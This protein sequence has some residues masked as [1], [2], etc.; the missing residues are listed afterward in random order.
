MP[1]QK[2]RKR[3]RRGW[4]RI[5]QAAVFECWAQSELLNRNWREESQAAHFGE[6]GVGL[7]NEWETSTKSLPQEDKMKKLGQLIKYFRYGMI[8]KIMNG[9]IKVRWYEKRIHVYEL[10]RF[11]DWTG[12][13]MVPDSLL[14]PGHS[15]ECDAESRLNWGL[16]RNGKR[17][18]NP[19]SY[20][21]FYCPRS[22]TTINNRDN[23]FIC[24]VEKNLKD[25]SK[26]V[27]IEGNHRARWH[28]R[29]SYSSFRR[30]TVKV[31][32]VSDLKDAVPHI[33]T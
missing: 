24:I 18:T 5:S 7:L 10:R 9:Q 2:T 25:F 21:K 33:Q 32:V 17:K 31:G 20:S 4:K 26:F 6:K 29:D 19:S 13:P 30:V 12:V 15:K 23:G 11:R 22:S 28:L 27:L 3:K 14:K 8:P 1:Y 16:T